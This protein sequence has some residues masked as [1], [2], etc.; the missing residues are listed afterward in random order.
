MNTIETIEKVDKTLTNLEASFKAFQDSQEKRI[1]H[2]YKS[3]QRPILELQE[4]QSSQ[5]RGFLDYLKSGHEGFEQKA[6]ASDPGRIGGYLI[7]ETVVEKISQGMQ[8]TSSLRSLARI[9]TISGDT[10]ELLL[11]KGS[12]DVGWV[13]EL[14]ERPET[15]TP[16]FEKV[17]ISVH[18]I[19]AKPRASQKILDDARID[20]ENWL[21]GKVAE[22]MA[23]SENSAF[24]HGDGDNKPKGFL[25]YPL[26]DVGAGEWGKIES[27]TSGADGKFVKPDVLLDALNVMKPQYLHGAVWLMSRSALASIRKLKDGWDHYIWQPSLTAGSPSTLFGYPVIVNDEMPSLIDGKE[28]TSIVFANFHEAYQI[29]DRES[30]H[31]LRDPYSSKPYVEFYVTKRV[32]GD[33]INFDA[34]KAIQFKE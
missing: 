9:T 26:V 3:N 28:S 15:G 19:Y 30:M 23:A 11:D 7:P 12:A 20:V 4:Y 14:A 21:V 32:G 34:I 1:Q 22:K 29:V 8:Q 17:R 25:S 6:L 24:I 31:V 5:N 2:I 18:Q 27:V 16:E 13:S 33:V 10:L